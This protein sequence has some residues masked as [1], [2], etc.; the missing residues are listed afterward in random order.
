MTTLAR[1]DKRIRVGLLSPVMALDICAARYSRAE[2]K[3]YMP[4]SPVTPIKF[5]S[6]ATPS[7]PTVAALNSISSVVHANFMFIAA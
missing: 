4:M 2:Q 3:G 6:F 7:C 1:I 5:R